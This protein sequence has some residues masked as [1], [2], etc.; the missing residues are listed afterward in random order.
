MEATDRE[1][2]TALKQDLLRPQ[3]VHAAVRKALARLRAPDDGSAP[4]R[5]AITAELSRVEGEIARLTAAVASGGDLSS[6]LEA[7]RERERRR[8]R[9]RAEVAELERAQ[10]LSGADVAKLEADLRDRLADWRGLLRRH[11][12]QARQLVRALLVGRLVFTPETTPDG[13]VYRFSGQVSLGRML[14]GEI[15]AKLPMKLESLNVGSLAEPVD[16]ARVIRAPPAS[17]T[18]R[19]RRD[20]SES[21]NVPFGPL[22]L[23]RLHERRMLVED[24]HG[25]LSRHRDVSPMSPGWLATDVPD[26]SVKPPRDGP[27]YEGPTSTGKLG[28]ALH[29]AKDPS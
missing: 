14:A 23:G 18:G 17:S 1:V 13:D 21:G 8:D 22:K 3:I 9:L 7:L 11:P 10:V 29:S 26:R 25:R 27:R 15:L 2:L 5:D 19:N 4:V 16:V 24:E 20:R 28:S 12:S 6:L